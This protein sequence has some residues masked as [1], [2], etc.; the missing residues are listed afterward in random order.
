MQIFLTP[1]VSLANF[2]DSSKARSFATSLKDCVQETSRRMEHNVQQ[3]N[4]PKDL[5][6]LIFFFLKQ[7]L[8]FYLITH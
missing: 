5:I 7:N 2:S 8:H 6:E 1:E 4:P 3:E